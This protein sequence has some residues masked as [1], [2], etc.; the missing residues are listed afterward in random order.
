M[1][2]GI[3]TSGISISGDNLLC[4]TNKT[5]TLLNVPLGVTVN[6]SVSPTSLFAV[7]TGTGSTFA[8]RATNTSSSGQGTITATIS[9]TC[10]TAVYNKS[11][12]VG[13][14][15]YNLLDIVTT[16]S[17]GSHKILACDYTLAEAEFNGSGGSTI[18]ISAYQWDMPYASN[19]YISQDAGGGGISMRYV[20]IEYFDDPPPST[21]TIKIRAQNSC[22]WSSWKSISV[23]VQD[24]CGFGYYSYSMSPNPVDQTLTIDF[25]DS[26]S[27]T[28]QLNSTKTKKSKDIMVVI[29]DGNQLQV[30]SKAGNTGKQMKLDVSSLMPGPYYIHL[31]ADGEVV[32]KKHLL[33]E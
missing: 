16:N 14:P 27:S 30:L 7:D 15:D 5:Y 22:G 6:W 21:E 12:W 20:E 23:T 24:N 32:N 1:S 28:T 26:E 33:V 19:W 9:G 3:P 11:V 2:V 25:T 8:T 18:G 4:S 17:G 13:G 29:Y 31:I 10:G